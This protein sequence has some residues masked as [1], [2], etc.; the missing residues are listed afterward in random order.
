MS[1]VMAFYVFFNVMKG[2]RKMKGKVLAIILSLFLLSASS[3]LAQ[4]EPC[5]AD[6]DCDLD[7]DADDASAFLQ[8]FGRSVFCGASGA[9]FLCSFS[10]TNETPCP[11]DLDCD[12]DVDAMDLVMFFEDFGRN[13]FNNPCP[14]CEVGAWCVY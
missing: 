6:F 11:S 7:V 12:T 5:A 4:G 3:V 13:E 8:D 14:A 2:R 1:T 10:C 9:G